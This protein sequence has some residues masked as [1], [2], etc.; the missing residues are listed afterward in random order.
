[1]KAV[2]S[3]IQSAL[4]QCSTHSL[5]NSHIIRLLNNVCNLFGTIY[6]F[7]KKNRLLLEIAATF[8]YQIMSHKIST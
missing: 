3:L 5:L 4:T 6:I 2:I 1:M 8:S 7:I